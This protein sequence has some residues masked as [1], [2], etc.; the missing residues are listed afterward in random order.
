MIK[1]KLKNGHTKQV[2]L[3]HRVL[4]SFKIRGKEHRLELWHDRV[5]LTAWNGRWTHVTNA[6]MQSEFAGAHKYH[7]DKID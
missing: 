2:R 3:K 4:E 5:I 6:V 7:G 1:I